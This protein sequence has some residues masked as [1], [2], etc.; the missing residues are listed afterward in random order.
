MAA[1]LEAAASVKRAKIYLIS[2]DRN[3]L[4]GR[5]EAIV[6]NRDTTQMR[7][8]F[9]QYPKRIGMRFK[10]ENTGV[11]ELAMKVNDG[12]TN[13]AADIEN[14]FRSEGRRHII[15][16][17]LAAPEQHLIQNKWIGGT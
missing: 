4:M 15:L 10:P 12:S 13:V 7:D 5:S 3:A 14:D 17:F 2:A 8:I 11:R 6:E 9:V 1:I 16:C